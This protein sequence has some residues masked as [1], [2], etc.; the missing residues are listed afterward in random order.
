MQRRLPLA[1]SLAL[2]VGGR[3]SGGRQHDNSRT[4]SLVPVAL[5]STTVR[6]GARFRAET[7]KDNRSELDG[8]RLSADGVWIFVWD[9][10]AVRFGNAGRRI[11]D[12]S[13]SRSRSA[14][15]CRRGGDS[16]SWRRQTG[17]EEACRRFQA[18][19]GPTTDRPAR[20]PR[21][22]DR[23]SPRGSAHRSSLA[24]ATYTGR[25]A[26]RATSSC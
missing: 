10:M 24:L 4:A 22:T 11:R 7:T 9:W 25:G 5:R 16:R 26:I 14:H 1:P 2:R 12:T 17:S 19:P 18:L 8:R 15:A 6:N 20:H 23:N 21:L 3:A 13:A